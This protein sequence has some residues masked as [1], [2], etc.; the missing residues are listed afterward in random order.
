MSQVTVDTVH[1]TSTLTPTTPS[2]I[3]KT[4]KFERSQSPLITLNNIPN[5]VLITD[6]GNFK[7]YSYAR[8]RGVDQTRIAFEYDGIPLADAEDNG[9]Y[10]SNYG[11]LLNTVSE[12]TAEKGATVSGLS[13]SYGGRVLF[14]P[15]FSNY[16]SGSMSNLDQDLRFSTSG[17][18]I[19]LSAA[20]STSKGIR[21]NSG[22]ENASAAIQYS[23]NKLKIL[24]ILGGQR[25]D[26]SWLGSTEQDIKQNRTH[27]QSSGER[28]A[29]M[30]NLT[31]AKYANNGFVVQPYFN[32]LKG[33]Y[34]FN[35]N[36]F[37]YQD[38][39]DIT[40]YKLG[41]RR[42]GLNLAKQVLTNKIN[43]VFELNS[44]LFYRD[45][46][47]N[48]YFN[49]GVKKEISGS[50]KVEYYSGSWKVFGIIQNRLAR[51]DYIG[52][53]YMNPI[54]WNFFNYKAG[55]GN[56]AWFINVG[57]TSKEPTRT[58]L[59]GGSENLVEVVNI[60]PETSYSVESGIKL[61]GS[62]VNFYYNQYQNEIALNGQIGVNSLPLKSNI[63][64]SKRFG[65]E[66][67]V[68]KKVKGFSF[69]SLG[70][71][72]RS[73][74]DQEN[75]KTTHILSPNITN[76]TSI[77]YSHNMFSTSVSS[78]YRSKMFINTENTF[79]TGDLVTFDLDFS[80]NLYKNLIL[81]LKATNILNSKGYQ[82][83]NINVNGDPVYFINPYRIV[84]LTATWNY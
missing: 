18:K 56:R 59:F 84:R 5:S 8:I 4:T 42:Y 12:V 6:N 11:A 27:N 83:G 69:S 30:Q 14:K 29:F 23:N 71:F 40:V 48:S 47:S 7:G 25:N 53:V 33:N 76:N 15:G 78:N 13:S 41:H 43:Y 50:T 80:L 31:Y 77:N 52:D 51:F 72:S 74:I 37:L 21:D 64:K 79:D 17:N 61:N 16:V 19:S 39:K 24:S 9:V 36:S 3:I 63:A 44:S 66:Y 60:V 57:K 73:L 20:V 35:L 68:T 1:I 67:N 65:V 38:G 82:H 22:N 28:D 54:N 75:T 58:D 81:N 26:L 2:N 55:I 34:D 10:L 70:S 32:F 45:H 49:T 62:S 46:Y